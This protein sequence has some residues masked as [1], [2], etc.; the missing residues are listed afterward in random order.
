MRGPCGPRT[1]S[2]GCSTLTMLR[3]NT[4]FGFYLKL[5]FF[6]KWSLGSARTPKPSSVTIFCISILGLYNLFIYQHLMTGPD[7]MLCAYSLKYR[8]T[9]MH[10]FMD[11]R[12]KKNF[13]LNSKSLII[14]KGSLRGAPQYD[15]ELKY[16]PWPSGKSV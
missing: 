16:Q 11:I 13:L 14:R 4:I 3:H 7:Y 6:P 15:Y 10:M 9:I 5:R 12:L 1:T 2:Y 8:L